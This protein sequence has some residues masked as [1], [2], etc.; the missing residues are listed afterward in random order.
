MSGPVAAPGMVPPGWYP[1]PDGRQ[2]QRWWDG[3]E[4]TD[5]TAPLPAPRPTIVASPE[6]TSGFAI[7]SL[8]LGLVGGSLL[9]VIFGHIALRR[10][11]RSWGLL[12]GR[13]MAIAGLVLGYIG[14]VAAIA[15]A[16]LI[17][18]AYGNYQTASSG[19]A[20]ESD[21]RNAVVVVEQ[22]IA[23]DPTGAF[24]RSTVIDS[25]NSGAICPGGNAILSLDGETLTYSTTGD[26]YTI[27]AT[28]DGQSRTYDSSSGG[29]VH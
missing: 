16:A 18:I 3:T 12:T 26:A 22:C 11:K 13:G 10:I 20:L 21:V 25:G 7:A 5:R 1:D 8:V 15:F 27:T 24:P 28:A 2:A 23:F 29:S 14:M 17:V 19:K 9:A 6:K 4:W